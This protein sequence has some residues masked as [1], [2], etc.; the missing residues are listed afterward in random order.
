MTRGEQDLRAF[1]DPTDRFAHKT[2]QEFVDQTAASRYSF[3]NKYLGKISAH[4]VVLVESLHAQLYGAETAD[5]PIEKDRRQ[6]IIAVTHRYAGHVATS[7][8]D[9]VDRIT[10][11]RALR[12]RRTPG[13]TWAELPSPLALA[14]KV[15]AITAHEGVPRRSGREYFMHPQEVASIIDIAWGKRNYVDQQELLD[16]F[17]FVAYYH[18]AYEDTIDAR[19]KYLKE[20][21]AIFTPLVARTLLEKYDVKNADKIA[22]VLLYMTRIKDV[23]GKRLPYADYIERGL[24]LSP[25]LFA[26]RDGVQAST[27]MLELFCTG[28]AADNQH[29]QNIEPDK[30]VPGDT[31]T[32]QK[33]E[34]RAQYRDSA[35]RIS[36]MTDILPHPL[37]VPSIYEVTSDEVRAATSRQYPFDTQHIAEQVHQ[38]VR[39]RFAA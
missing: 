31:K 30:I 7:I 22:R 5:L 12:R 3:R 10:S 29:N 23:E 15:V 38:E 2:R 11:D 18:D 9:V 24:S 34:K 32:Q 21:P 20:K 14:G 17:E 27:S 35:S 8:V 13:I 25:D 16:V 6:A 37:L 33:F 39:T 36:L 19:A 26:V 28:K 1:Y 4:E